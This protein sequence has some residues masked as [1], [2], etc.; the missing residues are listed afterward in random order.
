MHH[1]RSIRL[2]NFDYASEGG[3]FITIVTHERQQL[4]GEIIAGEMRANSYGAVAREEWFRTA[5][6]RPYVVLF[7]EEFVVMPNH[8]HGIISLTGRGTARRA[9][10]MEEIPPHEKFGNPVSG[11]IPTIV[12]AYKSAV[13][14]RINE[15]R[16]AQS[17][18]VWQ[19][20]YFEH[21]IGH[22][23]EYDE[24]VEYIHSN[25]RNWTVD[26]EYLE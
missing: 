3:Y 13:T 10:T 12:R 16:G 14:R 21:V 5:E 6:L 8:T 7:E 22:D 2:A 26:D 1:R 18:S 20:N 4:F 25:P 19:R 17:F 23:R 11:S 15:I 24:I 9:P